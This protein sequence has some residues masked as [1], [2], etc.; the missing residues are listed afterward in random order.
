MGLAE[1]EGR[2]ARIREDGGGVEMFV[3]CREGDVG[4]VEEVERGVSVV[5]EGWRGWWVVVKVRWC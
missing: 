3:D 5:E 2:R 4:V 1:G